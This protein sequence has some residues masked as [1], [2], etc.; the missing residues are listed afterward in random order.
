MKGKENTDKEKSK[1]NGKGKADE[2]WQR[3]KR[4]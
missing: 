4:N 1:I 3:K 2:L